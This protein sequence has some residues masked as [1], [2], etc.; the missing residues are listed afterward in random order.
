MKPLL[1]ALPGNEAMAAAL[2]GQAGF[3][4]RHWELRAFPDGESHV[5]FLSAPAGRNV[6][7]VCS[8]DQPDPELV[9]LCL[10]AG[11]AREPGAVRVGLVAPY[12]RQDGRFRVHRRRCAD[13]AGR[14]PRRRHV[15][16]RL[17][18]GLETTTAI[19]VAAGCGMR[20]C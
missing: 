7:L 2:C 4:P 5:R 9:P 15:T 17:V 11:A 1:F 8:L 6:V 13:G 18:F 10:A 19:A 20:R 14:C 16:A 12:L 3:E